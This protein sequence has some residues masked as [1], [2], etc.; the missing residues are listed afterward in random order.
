[1][2]E[3]ISVLEALLEEAHAGKPSALGVVV[4]TRGSTP[5]EPGAVMLIMSD[6]RTVGTVGG[7]AVEH[8]VRN[9]SVEVISAGDSVLLSYSMQGEHVD[10][11]SPICGGEMEVAIIPVT[12]ETGLDTF[13]QVVDTAHQRQPSVLSFSVQ[14]EGKQ[15]NYRLKMEVQP[16]LLLVGAGHVGLAVAQLA[17]DLDFHV[18]V[19]D[20]REDF[21]SAERFGPDVELKVGDMAGVLKEFPIDSCSYVVIVT[22]GHQYDQQTLEAVIHSEAGY[23]GMIASK[24]K[25]KFVLDSL[26]ESGVAQDSLDRI[27][28]P[29]GLSIGAVTV[30]EIAISIMAELVQTRRQTT[31][32]FVEGPY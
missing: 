22:R 28:T 19:I 11:E 1:M 16:T 24:R 17:K 9:K 2:N 29:I 31:P 21:A 32:T 23:I 10:G 7:G 20:D 4:K 8:E 18:V 27:H 13:Q 6:G 25:A 5:R 26:R 3:I 30:P 15:L 12:A 14:H